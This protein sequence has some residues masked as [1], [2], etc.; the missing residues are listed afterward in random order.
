M[1]DVVGLELDRNRVALGD[2][3]VG[4]VVFP[5]PSS[6]KLSKVKAVRLIV[7]AKISGS[8]NSETLPVTDETLASGP[9]SGAP[10]PFAVRLPERG[11]VT[12]DGRHVK[13]R[14]EI[15][16]E[17]DIPWA[18]DPKDVGTFVVTA[19]GA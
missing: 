15:I 1:S 6:E 7:R 17:L 10:L 16:A 18:I 9:Q 4:R 13:V 11:P 2:E 12:W 19:R 5:E 8:G 14:W 3:L